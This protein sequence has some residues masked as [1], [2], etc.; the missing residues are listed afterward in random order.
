MAF[1]RP[2]L[3]VNAGQSQMEKIFVFQLLNARMQYHVK[4]MVP[5]QLQA[6]HALLTVDVAISRC[7]MK[8]NCSK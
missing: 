8:I 7:A 5:A 6:Q 1:A 2:I 4:P 3:R